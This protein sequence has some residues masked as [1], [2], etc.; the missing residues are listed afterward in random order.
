MEEWGTQSE[1]WHLQSL[2][3]GITVEESITMKSLGLAGG[4]GVRG[5]I[6]RVGL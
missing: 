6:V 3:L 5:L 1:V 4:E 2:G